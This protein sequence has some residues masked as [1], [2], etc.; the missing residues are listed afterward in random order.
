M[1][2]GG[3]CVLPPRRPYLGVLLP[4]PGSVFDRPAGLGWSGR[5]RPSAGCGR[6]FCRRV[7]VGG[8]RPGVTPRAVDAGTDRLATPL[9]TGVDAA[10]NLLI[11]DTYNLPHPGGGGPHRQRA[12]V[13]RQRLDPGPERLGS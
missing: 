11:V 3:G 6:R 9:A 2:G 12:V 13:M 10:G 7:V 8:R 1:P 4:E 5:A